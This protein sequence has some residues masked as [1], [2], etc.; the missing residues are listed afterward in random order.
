MQMVIGKVDSGTYLPPVVHIKQVNSSGKIAAGCLSLL[1]D[2]QDVGTGRSDFSYRIN[3]TSVREIWGY[4]DMYGEDAFFSVGVEFN[5]GP[6]Q[7]IN[8][9]ALRAGAG[10]NNTVPLVQEKYVERRK[11]EWGI[12]DDIVSAFADS[13]CNELGHNRTCT[14][15]IMQ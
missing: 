15:C 6:G 9:T 11:S 2:E 14:G 7:S 12:N 3:T 8:Y 10:T 4:S 1:Y 5:E 13:D